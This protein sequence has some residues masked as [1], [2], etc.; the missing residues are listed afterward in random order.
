MRA[1]DPDTGCD[2]RMLHAWSKE[3][4]KDRYFVKLKINRGRGPRR[5][6]SRTAE[7]DPAFV[8]WPVWY[9]RYLATLR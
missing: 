5:M 1:V 6:A 8:I 9:R 3:R 7:I 2:G 4:R